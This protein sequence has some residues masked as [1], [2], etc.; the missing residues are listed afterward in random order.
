MQSKRSSPAINGNMQD[1]LPRNASRE[2]AEKVLSKGQ[3]LV[4]VLMAALVA[5]ALIVWPIFALQ[6]ILAAITLVYA[7]IVSLKVALG[8]YSLGTS[9]DGVC[10]ERD[11]AC[12]L[13]F[14]TILC[15]LYKERKVVGRLVSNLSQ[16][17]YP[18]DRVEVLLLIRESDSETREALQMIDMPSHFRIVS[19]TPGDYG[20]KPAALNVGLGQARG[21]YF[22]IYDAENGPE[23]LQLKRAAL[24]LMNAAESVAGV[25]SIPVVSNWKSRRWWDRTIAKFQA[26]EYSS[27]Y[28]LLNPALLKLGMPAPLPGNSVLFRTKMVNAVGEYDRFNKAEDADMAIRLARKGWKI[29]GISSQTTE[30][31]PTAYGAWERQRRRWIDGFLQTYLVHM[32]HPIVLFKELG[33]VNFVVFQLVV[34]G[35]PFVLLL[36]PLLW[37]LTVS[38]W[39]TRSSFI[40][41]LYPW[42]V[43][44]VGFTAAALGY[45][46]FYYSLLIGIMKRQMYANSLLMFAA[47]IYW[48]LMS[49]AAYKAVYDH[50]FAHDYWH[51]TE[52]DVEESSAAS[53]Q[54]DSLP[55]VVRAGEPGFVQA[56]ARQRSVEADPPAH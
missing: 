26:A 16:L 27:H 55:R 5:V 50:L 3:L 33:A 32:R 25:Q 54:A 22:T 42:P 44:Y 17:E 6:L 10:S 15:P 14:V 4:L 46:V 12:A 34:G 47:P 51:K 28:D 52:H 11:A 23:P 18:D 49:V 24:T 35:T 7:T 20:T 13:P 9:D 37:F 1:A 21:E 56:L 45:F 30:E 8:V 40:Q 2:T 39:S 36:N 19:V 53:R 38:Y 31:A 48:A 41:E 29:V 43:M